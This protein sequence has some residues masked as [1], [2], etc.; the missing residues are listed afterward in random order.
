MDD[1]V[2]HPAGSDVARPAH[3]ERNAQRP[4][5]VGEIVAAPGARR[6]L[7]GPGRLGAVVAGEH[8]NG[9]VAN[10]QGLNRVEQLAHVGVHLRERVGEVAVAGLTGELRVRQAREMHL[11]IGDVGVERP[12]RGHAS[13]H[14]VDG[15]VGAG[16]IDG[17]APIQVVDRHL[18]ALLAFAAFHDRF[19]RN[20]G[21]LRPR[22][23][24]PDRLVGGA[25]D[26]VPLV[27]A[28]VVG[29]AALGAAQMPLAAHAGGV[30][31]RRQGLGDGHLP[32]GQALQPAAD[33][34]G[35]GAR[36]D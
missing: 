29:Q 19:G 4:L 9:V 28:L 23:V 22:V 35:M 12:V 30:A 20:A 33:G 10:P 36:P 34:H 27:E 14:E 25:R 7:P 31:R 32:L 13:L 1:L 3:D 6:S 5:H 8:E 2:A 26:A 15:A 11:G 16:L 21:G 17:P 18:A 24:G